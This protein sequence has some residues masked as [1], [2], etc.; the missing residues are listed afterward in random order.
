MAHLDLVANLQ[1]DSTLVAP[2]TVAF[3][4]GA[5][6]L[7]NSVIVAPATMTFAMRA[8]LQGTSTLSADASVVLGLAVPLRT[9]PTRTVFAGQPIFEQVDFF[10][11]DG[12]TRQQ[13][14]APSDL[15]VKLFV[16]SMDVPWSVVSGTGIA[17]VVISSGKVYFQEFEAG[18][19]SFRFFPNMLGLWRIVLTWAAG[20]QGVSQS[21]DVQAKPNLTAGL[22]L[23]SSFT[24]PRGMP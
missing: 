8:T 9:L 23:R 4:M 5:N 21:Y 10:K 2:A 20:T 17:D 18:Y 12:I 19:Y 6:L 24:K 15:T 16:G 3:A 22:G 1:G 13:G 7:G 11:V 14:I